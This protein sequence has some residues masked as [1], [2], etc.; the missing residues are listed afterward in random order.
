M[1]FVIIEVL[2]DECI[3]A[4]HLKECICD[5]KDSVYH[6][7]DVIAKWVDDDEAKAY[8][9]EFMHPKE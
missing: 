3:D 6:E 5:Q 2:S 8:L 1:G 4:Q 7:S 9:E